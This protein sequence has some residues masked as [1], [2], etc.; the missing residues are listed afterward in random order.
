MVREKLHAVAGRPHAGRP[1]RGTAAIADG[2]A[3]APDARLARRRAAAAGASPSAEAGTG[4]TAIKYDWADCCI[5]RIGLYNF[6]V[7]SHAY[8][9][10]WDQRADPPR[11]RPLSI[12]LL[13]TS[14]AADE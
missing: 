6:S 12:C 11:T 4:E 14:D 7:A 5:E 13:Y 8:G 2:E 9:G 1:R 10:V 3:V